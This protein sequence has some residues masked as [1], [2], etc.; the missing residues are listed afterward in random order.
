LVL[1]NKKGK[2]MNIK[3]V[4]KLFKFKKTELEKRGAPRYFRFELFFFKK[5]RIIILE[6]GTNPSEN[7]RWIEFKILNKGIDYNFKKKKSN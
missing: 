2:K 4:N 7:L 1:I 6:F 3:V 5:Y